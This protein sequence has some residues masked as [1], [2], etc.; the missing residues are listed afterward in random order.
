MQINAVGTED[1]IFKQVHP[2]FAVYE[3]Y[4]YHIHFHHLA[5]GYYPS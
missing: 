4:Y 1:E 5:S 2:I 3:V